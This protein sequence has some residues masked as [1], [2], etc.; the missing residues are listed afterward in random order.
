M[1]AMWFYSAEGARIIRVESD[2]VV[3]MRE[4]VESL[5][6]VSGAIVVSVLSASVVWILCHVLPVR[7]YPLWILAVPFVFA[8]CLYWLP[9]WL[10]ADDVAQYSAWSFLIVFW[11]LAGFFPSAFIALIFRKRRAG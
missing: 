7:F 6:V 10:G 2:K 11:F 4:L 1:V 5:D 3:I 9:V 8:Y